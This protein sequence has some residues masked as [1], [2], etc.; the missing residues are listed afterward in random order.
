M[1]LPECDGLLDRVFDEF[2]L[3]VCGWS[4]DWDIALRR[5][6]ERCASRR[7]STYWCAKGV[8]T[9]KGSDV[10]KARDG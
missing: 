10:I 6:M 8:P 3:V 1:N 7:F 5:A 9:V 2:G 4:G